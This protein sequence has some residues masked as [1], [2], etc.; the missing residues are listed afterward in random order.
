MNSIRETKKR[1]VI[2]VGSGAAGLELAWSFKKKLLLEKME[3]EITLI[4]G[5]DKRIFEE[6]GPF[7]SSNVYKKLEEHHITIVQDKAIEV[8]EDKLVLN[9][10][11]ELE[12]DYL[13]WATGAKAPNV[14]QNTGLTLDDNGYILV[15]KYL[16]SVSHSNVFAVGDCCNFNNMN[17]PKAGVYSVREVN[18]Y[19]LKLL[20]LDR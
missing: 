20:K 11:K 18:I 14:L 3:P 1:K 17:L 6:Y 5:G 7:V 8:K 9:S 13:V 2:V 15:N 19:F 10:K 4:H 12:F 16:Q